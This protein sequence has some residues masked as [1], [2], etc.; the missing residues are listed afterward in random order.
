MECK[1]ISKEMANRVRQ[2]C[3]TVVETAAGP[4]NNIPKDTID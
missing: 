2:N 4:I 3:L 1:E